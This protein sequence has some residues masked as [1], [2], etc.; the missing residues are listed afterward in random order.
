VP[1][2]ARGLKL[3]DLLARRAAWAAGLVS[4]TAC[5][6]GLGVGGGGGQSSMPSTVVVDFNVGIPPRQAKIE[7]KRCHPLAIMGTDA[8]RIHGRSVTSVLIWGPQSGT[9]GASALYH[10]LKAAH[11]VV[12]QEWPG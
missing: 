4:L 2:L 9:A 7:V 11:G 12:D 1:P 5:S 3:Q 10:C 6:S 8:A